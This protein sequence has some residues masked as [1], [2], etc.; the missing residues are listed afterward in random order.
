MWDN[1]HIWE[2]EIEKNP[3]THKGYQRILNLESW[4]VWE[5]IKKRVGNVGFW[6]Q[7]KT[8]RKDEIHDNNHIISAEKIAA[9][10]IELIQEL[11]NLDRLDTFRWAHKHII[12][13]VD[14]CFTNT[15]LL[16]LLKKILW[17]ENFK[18][19]V[20]VV[21][22]NYNEEVDI[23]YLKENLSANHVLFILGGSLSDTY[24][25]RD[26]HYDSPLTELI[27][28]VSDEYAPPYLN[29]RIIWVCFGQ[30]FIANN[31]W[32][33]NKD[34]AGI[35]ATI[36]WPP[37]FWP[38]NCHIAWL[39]YVN[40][41]FSKALAW[42]SDNG[43]NSDFS[44]AFTRSGHVSFDLL[45]SGWNLWV[46]PL[47]T[48][49]ITSWVVGWGSKNGNILWVQFHPEIEKDRYTHHTNKHLKKILPLITPDTGEQEKYLSNF[50]IWDIVKR[51]I[52]E[53]F[54]VFA[55]LAYIK[56]IRE[57]HAKIAAIG[58][59]LK[60]SDPISYP[61]AITR[62]R[63][64]FSRRV[65]FVMEDHMH[66]SESER[67]KRLID[68]MD[69]EGVIRFLTELDWKVG[70]NE[71][72]ASKMAW[73][74]S[75][76]AIIQEHSTLQKNGNPLVNYIVRDLWA[77]D[78]STIKDL[79]KKLHGQD[80]IFYGTGDYLYFDLFAALNT[81]KF[82]KTIPKELR[83]LFVEKAVEAFK[84]LPWT[85][86]LERLKESIK[87]LTFSPD[88]TIRNSSM[89]ST[90]TSMFANEQG[91]PLSPKIRENFDR[92]LVKLA[93]LKEYVTDHMYSLFSGYLERIYISKFNDLYIQDDV[94]S[95]IDFQYSI[96][97]TSHVGGREYMKVISDYCNHAAKL[98]SIYIDNG[99][100]Q[101]YTS[102]PRIKELFNLSNDI[103]G[104]DFKLIYNTKKNTFSSVIITHKTDH[105]E[106][107]W[108][109]HLDKDS[110][111]ISLKEAHK[112]TFFQLEYFIRTFIISSFKSN[113]VF[114]DFSEKI[115]DTLRII[116]GELEKG[117]KEKISGLILSLINH[118]AKNYQSIGI[119]YNEIESASLEMYNIDG[120]DLY[121][122]LTRDIYTPK[123][124]NIHA[125]RDY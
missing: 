17:K 31:I 73:V 14:D 115:E 20:K 81:P 67:Q 103:P 119:Q 112:A 21:K 18:R 56:D 89:T 85:L 10:K 35:I 48:D 51:D 114:R 62:V 11:E 116:M 124:M 83:V 77:G 55:M 16:V 7:V 38:S 111:L 44:S 94:I 64:I 4:I 75:M 53:A 1:I 66:L 108:Q 54:Y 104:C 70:R 82:N 30:Q 37:Q 8:L 23:A 13:V 69:Q 97:A 86:T 100:H 118:I 122:I 46:V 96:R 76:A 49:D 106:N 71:Q 87:S 125:K 22:I 88:D 24:K 32:I 40:P 33:A 117:N 110:I 29:K 92:S 59:N 120:E 50:D 45:G 80:I 34:S 52:G 42:L 121:T 95:Q 84:W 68:T 98:G 12:V 3:M 47:I 93:R 19:Y 105:G 109:K 79:Y 101:S 15:K 65:N 99:V 41:I 123:W 5:G 91:H 9:A 72:E 26:S 43:K 63:R 36:Q 60:I 25:M 61:E 2:P 78:G 102:I 57:S 107:F 39:K 113:I 28:E 27:K 6:N 58:N 90:K 74:K